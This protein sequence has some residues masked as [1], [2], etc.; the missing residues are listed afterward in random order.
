MENRLLNF[1]HDFILTGT[2]S[3]CDRPSCDDLIIN[4]CLICIITRLIKNGV[5]V[6]IEINS[7]NIGNVLLKTDIHFARLAVTHVLFAKKWMMF[8][9]NYRMLIFSIGTLNKKIMW[10]LSL[11]NL[12]YS[13]YLQLL[14]TKIKK[15]F[16]IQIAKSIPSDNLILNYG[17]TC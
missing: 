3:E 10:S 14:L 7:V 4:L 6:W 11:I 1:C 9:L 13:V 2:C 8:L 12:S 16:H 5:I 17:K 15:L